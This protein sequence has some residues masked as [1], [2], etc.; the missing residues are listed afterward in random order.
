MP[1]ET[2]GY[3]RLVVFIS[4]NIAHGMGDKDFQMRTILFLMTTP[5]DLMK[6]FNNG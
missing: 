2:S 3:E 4:D 1:N 6:N 5:V